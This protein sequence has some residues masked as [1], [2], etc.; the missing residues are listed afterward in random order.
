MCD[1]IVYFVAMISWYKVYYDIILQ[2]MI[3]YMIKTGGEGVE[4]GSEGSER[5]VEDALSD[6]GENQDV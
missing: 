3:S 6:V 5:E 2:L 4:R 1:I